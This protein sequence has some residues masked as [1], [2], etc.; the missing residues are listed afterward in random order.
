MSNTDTPKVEL[1]K[2]SIW[3]FRGAGFFGLGSTF[4]CGADTLKDAIAEFL[5]WKAQWSAW[6]N[7]TPEIK[8]AQLQEALNTLNSI[9]RVDNPKWHDPDPTASGK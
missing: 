5:A 1:E 9:E 4:E 3:I 7:L 2:R 6:S 8:A